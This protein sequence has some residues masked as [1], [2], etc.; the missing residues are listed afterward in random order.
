LWRLNSIYS[1]FKKGHALTAFED[2]V[3]REMFV[4]RREDKT[5]DCSKIPNQVLYDLYS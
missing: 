4:T 2:R 5:E 1:R 3:Q